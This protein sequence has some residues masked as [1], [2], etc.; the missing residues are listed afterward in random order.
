MTKF[1]GKSGV[2][3]VV[4]VSVVAA[5]III[6]VVV[7]NKVVHRKGKNILCFNFLNCTF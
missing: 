3:V 6:V 7:V 4:F 5:V 2:V 1:C